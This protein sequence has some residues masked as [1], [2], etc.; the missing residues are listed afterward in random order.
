MPLCT[1]LNQAL[2]IAEHYSH[3]FDLECSPTDETWL[4]RW[5]S[6]HTALRDSDFDEMLNLRQY[7]PF[8]YAHCLNR[9]EPADGSHTTWQ[10]DVMSV[11]KYNTHCDAFS[12]ASVAD[13]ISV[14]APFLAYAVD[15][16]TSV[17]DNL[18]Y[19]SN[20]QNVMSEL[21]ATLGKRLLR[22]GAK[23]LILEMNRERQAGHLQGD[24]EFARKHAFCV[25]LCSPTYREAL[26]GKYP[27]LTRFCTQATLDFLCFCKQLLGRLSD[28]Q[29]TLTDRFNLPK[30]FELEH[31][32]LDEGDLHDH[33]ASV[34]IL[35]VSG[36]R[37]VYKPRA[38]AMHRMFDA[39]AH[40]CERQE[41]FLPL[42]VPGVLDCGDYGFE[43]FVESRDC[44][45]VDEVERYYRRYGQIMGMV[46]LLNGNDMHFENIIPHGEYPQIVDFETVITNKVMFE[47]HNE[48]AAGI[49]E[50][51]ITH[52][53]AYSA[54]LP[55]GM[56]VNATGERI[57]VSALSPEPQK[58]PAVI[59]QAV[60]TD[61]DHAHYE[62]REIQLDKTSH[63][64]NL[65]GMAVDPQPYKE[66][67]L[68]GFNVAV[69]ALACIGTD[70]LLDIIGTDGR[71]RVLIRP[72]NSYARF[73]DFIYHPA[74]L[75]DM[76]D[77]EAILENLYVFPFTNKRIFISEYN[78]LLNGD[79]PLFTTQVSSTAVIGADGTVIEGACRQ[80][81]IDVIRTRHEHIRDE[82]GLQR[83]VIRNALGMPSSRKPLPMPKD[84]QD[85]DYACAVAEELMAEAVTDDATETI[86]W[87]S[88]DRTDSP[89]QSGLNVGSN[90]LYLGQTG[91]ALLFEELGQRTHEE[92]YSTFAR[93]CVE[94]TFRFQTAS[95]TQ[96]AFSGGL[97]CGYGAL[98]L[99]A[100]DDSGAL[101]RNL[102][103]IVQAMPRY[104]AEYIKDDATLAVNL[105][106]DYVTGAAG[107][108]VLL[109]AMHELLS[110]DAILDHADRLGQQ[111]ITAVTSRWD[112]IA[113]DD[114]FVFPYGAAH[115]LEGVALA[116][117]HLYGATEECEYARF[118]H[119]AWNRAA[120]RREMQRTCS[121]TK[122]CRGDIG[123]LWVQNELDSVSGPN[124]EPFFRRDEERPFPTRTSIDTLLSRA[125]WNDDTVCHGRCG[126][127][128][129]LISCYRSTNDVWYLDR[130]RQL[131]NDMLAEAYGEGSFK[132]GHIPEFVDLSYFLGPVGVA[133]TMLRVQNPTVPSILALEVN[134]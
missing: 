108:I 37:I 93:R 56:P 103:D 33:G 44:S 71:I 61:S 41:G 109:L 4:Q 82:A 73:Q 30:S 126:A 110:D 29:T 111:M 38:L 79:I 113:A 112:D 10:R 116:F 45:T 100:H 77:I 98:R 23:T 66:A 9:D 20:R 129:T 32:Q 39:L 62:H 104:T 121:L 63:V 40:R 35:T 24:D 58:M 125:V 27:V 120:W 87:L 34:A 106:V 80:S 128:D 86:A 131:I 84:W 1:Q 114:D 102:R 52:S 14:F 68:D 18:P 43:E 26:F 72:T 88:S 130:A 64:L 46:W 19:A 95:P 89:Q 101:R 15:G 55:S 60:E 97:S 90:E 36:R 133:Y 21:L 134:R 132:L 67:I 107:V 123:V 50:D 105:H 3:D 5:R 8:G 53:L 91:T 16:M 115:G 94:S 70:E 48:G 124:G 13:F 49:V 28:N 47:R 122:W 117:W 42:Q 7:T 85:T 31:V 51:T 17:F 99:L 12:D 2:T 6:R 96:S 11:W 81:A 92:R 57:D 76:R 69:N 78:Q 127:I 22:I 25:K 54:L 59:A 119:E 75:S 83:R 65:N 118:A 74:V